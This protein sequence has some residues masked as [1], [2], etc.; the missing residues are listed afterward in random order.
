MLNHSRA[1]RVRHH[2]LLSS[3]ISIDIVTCEVKMTYVLQCTHPRRRSSQ[4]SHSNYSITNGIVTFDFAPT[5][6]Y[7]APLS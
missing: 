7:K 4:Y 6:N 2:T 5:I 1:R 3:S